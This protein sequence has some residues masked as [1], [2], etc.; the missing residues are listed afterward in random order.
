MGAPAQCR[1]ARPQEF[2]G[3]FLDFLLGSGARHTR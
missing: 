3:G 1:F 2:A